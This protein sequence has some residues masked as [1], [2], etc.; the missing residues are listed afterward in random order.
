MM[1]EREGRRAGIHLGDLESKKVA[2]ATRRVDTV[3]II[4]LLGLA[5]TPISN[6]FCHG[7]SAGTRKMYIGHPSFEEANLA[8]I[9]KRLQSRPCGGFRGLEDHLPI[10]ISTLP[11]Q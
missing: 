6:I 4:R 9:P 5:S 11:C 3:G 2:G 7:N 1:G 8:P 10:H